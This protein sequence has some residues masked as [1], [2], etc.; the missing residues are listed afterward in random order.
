MNRLRSILFG[1]TM[2]LMKTTP[3]VFC[4]VLVGTLSCSRAPRGGNTSRA[5]KLASQSA[6]AM[7]AKD[8]PKAQAL[9]QQATS[10]D[11]QFAEAWVGYGMDSVQMAQTNL[12]RKAY[13]RALALCQAR[14]RKSPSDANPVNQEIFV[15]TLLG[16]STKAE[17]LLKQAR[18]DYPNDRQ[19]AIY[20]TNFA[21]F[22]HSLKRFIVESK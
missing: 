19:I 6:A 1:V 4:L 15:L 2:H 18:I 12:A 8:Y 16:R 11:P 3:L 5:Q 7:N 9:A 13:E 14:H 20:A 21:K 17:A 10:I 22:Q